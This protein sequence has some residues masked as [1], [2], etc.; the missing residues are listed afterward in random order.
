[1]HSTPPTK[2]DSIHQR[3]RWSYRTGG[4]ADPEAH[5]LQAAVGLLM[6]L[7]AGAAPAL[8][9]F[10]AVPKR[11]EPNLVLRGI[12]LA[13]LAVA[14]L[15]TGWAVRGGLA[16]PPQGERSRYQRWMVPGVILLGSFLRLWNLDGLPNKI[17]VDSVENGFIGLQLLELLDK[18]IYLPF[19]DRWAPGNESLL[20]YINGFVLRHIDTSVAALRLPAALIGCLTLPALYIAGRELF[21]ARAGLWATFLLAVSPW[22]LHMSRL[23][24]RA[25]LVPLVLA[26]L[27]AL[28]ARLPRRQQGPAGLWQAV[29]IGLVIGIGLNTYEAFRAAPL[30]LAGALLWVRWRQGALRQGMTEVATMA[31]AAVVVCL[32]ILVKLV[33]APEVY[34]GHMNNNYV[35]DHMQAT[36]TAAA[37]AKNAWLT[38]QHFLTKI[39]LKP[40]FMSWQVAPAAMVTPL[41]LFGL[42]GLLLP[43]LEQGGTS[44]MARPLLVTLLIFMALPFA[45]ASMSNYTP[46]RYCGELVPFYLLAGA[47]VPALARALRPALGRRVVVGL[48]VALAVA[49]VLSLAGTRTGMIDRI[50]T[51]P[52]HPKFQEALFHEVLNRARTRD[53]YLERH[54]FT[55]HYLGHMLF[56]VEGVHR[57]PTSWPLPQGPLVRDVTIIAD[58]AP[59]KVRLLKGIERGGQEDLHIAPGEGG[60]LLMAFKIS[61]AALARVRATPAAIRGSFSG[62]LMVPEDNIYT[63]R[64][65]DGRPLEISIRGKVLKAP[66]SGGQTPPTALAAGL[67]PIQYRNSFPSSAPLWKIGPNGP[68]QPIPPQDLWTYP[69]SEEPAASV[70]TV[71][72]DAPPSPSALPR[73]VTKGEHLSV[74]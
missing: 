20:F 49:L 47:A 63:F 5:S 44:A 17:D 2:Q 72:L 26:L 62:Y 58:P 23:N 3:W 19:L 55:E 69:E 14:L 73:T 9:P 31:A 22:H 15:A 39:P 13:A 37:V 6:L 1:M 70:P 56:S 57:L 71:A 8:F 50:Y 36:S 74:P 38:T 34:L 30:A 45:M 7:V 11:L 16:H 21:S 42:V 65:S 54:L 64:N 53:I 61:R 35:W 28:V 60:R 33:Q 52:A 29:L 32:P 25:I 4:V 43:R 27:V 46:R 12:S 59:W 10:E 24:K 68:W 40:F 67:S 41:F 48:G 18:G 51:S 66:W